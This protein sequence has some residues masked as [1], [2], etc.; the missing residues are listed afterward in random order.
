MKKL[1][2]IMAFFDLGHL[3]TYLNNTAQ[4]AD[5]NYAAYKGDLCKYLSKIG[6]VIRKRILLLWNTTIGSMGLQFGASRIRGL[7]STHWFIY[8]KNDK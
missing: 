3:N 5:V 6:V 2:I 4:N 8:E 1:I 7:F